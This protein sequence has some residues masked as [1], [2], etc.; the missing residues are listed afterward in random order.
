MEGTDVGEPSTSLPRGLR[1]RVTILCSAVVEVAESPVAT[2]TLPGSDES[3]GRRSSVAEG[4]RAIADK[5][6]ALPVD[7][8]PKNVR[9]EAAVGCSS[10]WCVKHVD[11]TMCSELSCGRESGVG[12]RVPVEVYRESLDILEWVL[13]ETSGGGETEGGQVGVCV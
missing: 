13:V 2:V 7:R 3:C 8:R 11:G 5:L 9:G 12:H 6:P 1:G 10:G 4:L